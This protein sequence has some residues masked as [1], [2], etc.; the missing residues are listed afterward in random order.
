MEWKSF[1]ALRHGRRQVPRI[2]ELEDLARL[3]N[4]EAPFVFEV[5][6][7]VPARRMHGLLNENDRERL[8][9]LLMQGALT[10]HREAESTEVHCEALLNRVSDG[11][12]AIDVQGRFRDVNVP[13]SVM[14]GYTAEELRQGSLFDLLPPQDKPKFVRAA[15]AVYENRELQRAVFSV[16]TKARTTLQLELGLTRIDDASGNP[17]GIQGIARDVTQRLQL[18]EELKHQHATL[19]MTFDATPAACMLFAKDATILL[20]NRLVE[21]VCEWTGEEVTGRNAFDVFGNPGPAGCPVTRAFQTGRVEQQ[22]SVVRNRRGD[23]VFVHRTAGPV[24]AVDGTTVERVVEILVDVTHQLRQGDPGLVSLW[25]QGLSQEERT[26]DRE[27]RHFVRVPLEMP[28]RYAVDKK[29]HAAVARNLGRGG[30]FL[31]TRNIVPVDGSV[32][33]EWSLPG[34]RELV[35]V[36]GMV[37][38]QLPG[39]AG[40]RGMGVRFCEIDEPCR[41][42]V[43]SFVAQAARR[44]ASSG[45]VLR[46][47]P[48]RLSR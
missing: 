19:K 22:I 5:A 29:R 9:R 30:I 46:R 18:E 10:A 16:I 4:L 37:A 45:Y 15:A 13:L 47:K 11:V 48:R 23:E 17:I 20:A 33:L 32:M 44:S 35:Q 14:T 41:D 40:A 38:W 1:N 27:K 2:R 3:L 12:F 43:A 42:A 25:R 6:R 36:K 31:R 8:Y 34:R 39:P 24:L 7:G 28:V 21:N 26:P